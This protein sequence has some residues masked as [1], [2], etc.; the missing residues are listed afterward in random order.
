MDELDEEGTGRG[1]VE[2]LSRHLGGGTEEI[3]D[4]RQSG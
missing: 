4:E 2:I 1:S 3:H